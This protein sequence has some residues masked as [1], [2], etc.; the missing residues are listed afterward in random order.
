M[1]DSTVTMAALDEGIRQQRTTQATLTL[2][3]AG[4]PLA[5]KEVVVAQKK[6]RF[7]L[8]SNWG[9]SSIAL[10]NGE[11][12]GEAKARAEQRNHYF[13]Q[14]F[15]QATLPFYWGRFEP[16]RG[17]PDTQRILNSGALV[18]GSGLRGQRASVMLAHRDGG[19]AAA[20]EQCRDIGGADWPHPA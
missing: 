19:L 14:L 3:H 5:N 2:N 18:P 7:L 10:A 20:A 11:L 13:L 8:G 9:A 6:H 15:N 17:Q 16:V 4:A 12:S 1:N